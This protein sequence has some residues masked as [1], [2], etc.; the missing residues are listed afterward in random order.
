MNPRE[1]LEVGRLAEAIEA[2]TAEVKANPNDADAR[3]QLFTLL[4]FAGDLERA[5]LQL[6]VIGH[7]HAE[8]A[9][10]AVTYQALLHAEA[11]RRAVYAG[12]ARPILPSEPVEP[13]VEERL[14]ALALLGKGASGELGAALERAAEAS[15]AVQGK[16]DGHAF[17]ALRDYDDL[18]STVLEI[19]AAGRY[20]WLPLT[21][22]V[23]L[24][25]RPPAR[26]LDLLWLPVHLEDSAG[27]VGDVHVP[28]LYAGSHAH[29]DEPVRL[30]RRTEWID[31]AGAGYRGAG[32]R[33]YLVEREGAER[34]VSLLSIRRLEVVSGQPASG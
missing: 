34:E 9:P 22:L 32:L 31:C 14:R 25:I 16:L 8:L 11:H 10:G 2:Q 17:A 6:D 29:V 1:L 33:T 26:R 15:V 28:A 27:N 7:Q 20:L 23:R 4:C 30:G 5:A 12:E 24:E 19:Y 3:F 21:R 13:D 18:V